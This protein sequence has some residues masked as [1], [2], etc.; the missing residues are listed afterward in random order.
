MRA[1][2]IIAL[3]GCGPNLH[4]LAEHRHYREAICAARDGSSGDR[5]EIGAALDADAG[6]VVHVQ[7]V[8][9]TQLAGVLGNDAAPISERAR[10]VRVEV[11][12]S[13]LPIDGLTLGA[14]LDDGAT[15]IASRVNWESLAR[16]TG[17]TLPP[18]RRDT[19][20]LTNGNV[21][22][23]LS[24]FLTMG[25]APLGAALIGH[26]YTFDSQVVEIDAPDGEYAKRAPRTHALFHAME[27]R[28]CSHTG[29]L[30]HDATGAR[31][32]WFFAM[33]RDVRAAAELKVIVR[34]SATR[35][36]DHAPP[37]IVERV[38]RISLGHAADLDTTVEQMFGSRMRTLDE[39]HAI[40]D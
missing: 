31:C 33:D 38:R 21:L 5:D 1:L 29:P 4:A 16:I 10:F 7:A 26:P 11:Q 37:C 25:L 27:D 6:L 20:Y 28:N 18:K 3:S 32:T 34:Y 9:P 39:I 36:D 14:E 15:P 24:A 30:S 17:E 2:A 22:R 12:T 13:S 35:A 40:V 8:S 19:T 23:G